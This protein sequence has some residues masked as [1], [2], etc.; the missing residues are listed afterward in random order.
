MN[1]AKQS[2]EAMDYIIYYVVVEERSLMASSTVRTD[3]GS[4]K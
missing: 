2:T 4:K 1:G 3:G